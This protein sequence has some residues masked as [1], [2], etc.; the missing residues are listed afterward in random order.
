MYK[1]LFLGFLVTMVAMQLCI[2]LCVLNQFNQLLVLPLDNNSRL[3][4]HR[5]IMPSAVTLA[6]NMRDKIMDVH[7]FILVISL[8]QISDYLVCGL[9]SRKGFFL[10]NVDPEQVGSSK[11][12]LLKT[13]HVP[14]ELA[15]AQKCFGNELCSYKSFDFLSGKCQLFKEISSD[16]VIMQKKVSQKVI[17][18]LNICFVFMHNFSYRQFGI[19]LMLTIERMM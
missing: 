11:T 3:D 10:D 9:G 7:A 1:A 4:M 8:S 14:S 16:D 6:P 13:V 5:I 19:R 17:V 18:S 12:V 2:Q 15:C